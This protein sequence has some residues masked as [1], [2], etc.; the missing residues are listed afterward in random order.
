VRV[1]DIKTIL[2]VAR[3]ELVHRG[4]LERHAAG[5]PGGRYR[6]RS[7]LQHRGRRVDANDTAA[8]ADVLG[9]PD[10]DMSIDARLGG[11]GRAWWLL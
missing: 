9:E 8:R 10:G 3:S 4:W 6:R 1:R 2:T 7:Q 11:G 5:E